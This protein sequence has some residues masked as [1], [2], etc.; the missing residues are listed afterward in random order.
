M[1]PVARHCY[2]SQAVTKRRMLTTHEYVLVFAKPECD[3]EKRKQ[4]EDFNIIKNKVTLF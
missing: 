4:E 1:S 3:I 2:Y